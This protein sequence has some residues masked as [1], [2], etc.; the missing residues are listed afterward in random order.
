MDVCVDLALIGRE[1]E[2]ALDAAKEGDT[3]VVVEVRRLFCEHV[4]VA[5]RV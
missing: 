4:A 2:P 5:V 1:V 3:G